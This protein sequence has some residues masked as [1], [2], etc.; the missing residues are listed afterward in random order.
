MNKTVIII[1]SHLD[2][3]RLPR[4]PLLDIS[5]KPMIV[6]VWERAIKSKVKDVFVATADQE[7][8][9]TI[10]S[11]GGNAVLTGKQHTTGS[12]RIHEAITK[13]NME[14]NIIINVQGD[15]P[16]IN[17]ITIDLLNDFMIS[18]DEADVA[19][20]ASQI[21]DEEILD[22]NVVKAIVQSN[23]KGSNFEK[24][25]DFV[26]ETNGEKYIY[27][28]V[29]LYAYR[30][31]AL[32]KFVELPKTKNE[33]T[34]SLEQMRF[35]DNGVDVFV[36]YTDDNPLSVDTKEDLEKIRKII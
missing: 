32:K 22:K 27:H 10:V 25:I 11:N 13:L 33:T 24:A 7:I 5:G 34:R 31:S 4:K 3:Q 8:V 18:N 28:H 26:R 19:T 2:A 21:L 17:P 23:L 30:V 1:P 35:L 36:G 9:D 29:G 16:N 15:M 6:H 12:D 20:V 14:N